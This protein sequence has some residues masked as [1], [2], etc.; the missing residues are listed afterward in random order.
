MNT[1]RVEFLKKYFFSNPLQIWEYHTLVAMADSLG[2]GLPWTSISGFQR[3]IFEA[4][5]MSYCFFY[6]QV[7]I[8]NNVQNVNKLIEDKQFS[9]FTLNNLWPVAIKFL[10]QHCT[11]DEVFH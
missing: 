2:V 10:H 1:L 6:F 9:R 4:H 5:V 11:K 8:Q 3:G 7:N